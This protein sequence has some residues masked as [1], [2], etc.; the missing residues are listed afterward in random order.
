M[1][2]TP[3]QR[4]QLYEIVS[5]GV[6]GHFAEW[7]TSEKCG[8]EP[9]RHVLNRCCGPCIEEIVSDLVRYLDGKPGYWSSTVEAP[10]L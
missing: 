5:S 9:L 10:K 1:T 7:G 6:A 3:E 4:E 8:D 2:V